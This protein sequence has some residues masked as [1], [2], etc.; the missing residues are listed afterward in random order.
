[1]TFTYCPSNARLRWNDDGMPFAEDYGDVYYSRADAL[2]E[3]SHVFLEGSAL[4]QRFATLADKPFVIG[5]LGFGAGL[6]FL[7]TCRLWCSVVAPGA[8]LH[9]LA[10]ELHPWQRDDL[11][12]L[13]AQFPQLE[14]WAKLLLPQL[15]YFCRGTH[16]L[17]L[18][19]GP[20]C[21]C[22]TLLHDDATSA[23]QRLAATTD[24]RIDAWFVDGFAPRTNPAM[25]QS[26]LLS[27]VAALSHLGTTLVS[28]S[29]AG[30]FRRTLEALG[31]VCNKSPGFAGK[32]HML[33]A[34]FQPGDGRP[35]RR[36]LHHA[37]RLCIVGGG[38][39]GCSTAHAFASAGWQVQLIEAGPQLASRASGNAQ[40]ILHFKPGTVD[41]PD[42]RFNLLAYLYAARRYQSLGLP[43]ELWSACGMLQLAAD[44]KL[45][46]R[47][48]TLAAS[49]LYA[50]EIL[51]V[52]DAAA[53]SGKVGRHLTSPALYFPA[54]GWLSPARL[55][56][57]YC[58]HP[59]IEVLTGH[60]VGQLDA[61]ADGWEV[62]MHGDSGERFVQASH[63]IL[64]NSADVYRFTQARHLPLICNRGQVDLYTQQ[65]AIA[66]PRVVC[67]Q[68]YIVPA[69]SDG[70][71]VGG[72][73]FLGSDDPA[74][75][76]RNRQQHLEQLAGIDPALAFHFSKHQPVQQ[77]VSE[78]C[79]LPGRMPVVGA[80]ER[81]GESGLWINVGHGSHGLART[82]ICAALLL[83]MLQG[84]PA[85]LD[86]DLQRLLVPDRFD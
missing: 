17:E 48:H 77:R 32:R 9:Y 13:W 81:H 14:P 54:A 80:L 16:Q 31:F 74:A 46:K 59:R 68:G 36:Q 86:T 45:V 47:F 82:P 7:N 44:P 26:A 6:N 78:R 42:N 23:L 76:E 25:W 58:A 65:H 43:P 51:Q 55:C 18:R 50:P 57:W 75:R 41:A 60:S 19:I 66:L 4:A 27:H 11:Q 28:Y 34:S 71:A 5:E 35:M 2:G 70:Q 85:P 12:R 67:G 30:E 83:S 69:G 37:R 29:V 38:L 63:V 49:G 39:A 10:C 22:L 53:A 84:T 72:S 56:A 21:I 1:M 62:L 64:C 33:Q 24:C 79:T 20:H 8:R 40:G 61:C 3:S 52:L 73:F 15:P